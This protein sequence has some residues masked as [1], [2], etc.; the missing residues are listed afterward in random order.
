MCI[1]INR[2]FPLVICHNMMQLGHD[3]AF[4]DIFITITS[5]CTRQQQPSKYKH[6]CL[7]TKTTQHNQQCTHHLNL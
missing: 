2:W 5:A 7:P 3:G 1:G 6:S 4:L